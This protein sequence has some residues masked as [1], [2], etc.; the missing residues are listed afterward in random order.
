M[1]NI[2]SNAF[3]G[4]RAALGKIKKVSQPVTK[5]MLHILPLWLGMNCTHTFM[6]MG[7]R[8]GREEKSYRRMFSKNIDWFSFNHQI[9]RECFQGKEVLP[10]YDPTFI[11]K[12]GKKTCGL[13]KFRS[14]K[15]RKAKKGL[16]TGCLSFISVEDHTALHRKKKTS[17][18]HHAGVIPEHAADIQA[19]CRYVTVAGQ[20]YKEGFIRAVVEAGFEVITKARCD[21]NLRSVYRGEQKAKGRK[22]HYEGKVKISRIDKKRI[23]LICS[24]KQKEVYG[25]VVHSVPLRREVLA[26]FIY[27]RDRKTGAIKK[28]RKGRKKKPERVIATDTGMKPLTLC[29]YYSLRYQAEFLIRDAKSYAGLEDCQARSKEK[30]NNHF[31]IAMTFVSVAK[32]ACCLSLPKKEQVFR[33]QK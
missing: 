3:G 30:L 33:W 15:D 28:D 22:R 17:M 23:P 5:F 29:E 31:N 21:A 27:Y 24:D 13:A 32:A 16:E 14:S 9:A 20:F 26:A 10:A 18:D 7:R 4:C 8:G 1:L 25:A 6:N 11:K 12:S 2:I 19:L